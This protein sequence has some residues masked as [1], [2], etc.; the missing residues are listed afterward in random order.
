MGDARLTDDVNIDGEYQDRALRS[1]NPIQRYWHKAKFDLVDKYCPPVPG[2]RMLDAG[3]GSGCLTHYLAASGADV[4]GVDSNPR[5]IMF[6]EGRFGEERC[7]FELGQ[8]EEFGE[9][10]VFDR[11]YCIEVIEHLYPGQVAS[12]LGHFHRILRPSGQL[13]LT[14]P[15]ARSF[16]PAIEWIMDRFRLAPRMSATQHVS[17]YTRVRLTHHVLVAGFEVLSQGSFNGLAPFASIFGTGVA[18]TVEGIERRLSFPGNLLFVVA[19]K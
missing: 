8:F 3:C 12:L 16:W 7:R 17:S 9:N 4:L 11:I 5:A 15:N 13:L 14:T 2:G 18:K 19:R 1:R 10:E 6:A